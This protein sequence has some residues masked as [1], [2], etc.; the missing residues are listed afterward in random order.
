[1][2]EVIGVRF[3]QAG[4]IYYFDPGD[5]DLTT[6]DYVI[7]ETVRGVE[8]GKVVISN[9]Q[10]DEEDVVLPLKKVIRIADDKD[11]LTVSENNEMTEEAVRTCSD[12][13]KEHQL[14]MNLVDAEYTFDRN[15]IIFYFTADGRV[16]FRHL[17]K[18]LAAVF[19]TRIELRQIG[20][21]DE[22]KMLGGIGPC[23]RMLCCSTF[24]GD[25]EP[26]SIK[27]AKDQN[28]S[29]NPAKISGLCGRLMC[30]LKYENDMYEDAKQE[31]PDIGERLTTSHGSGKVV[32]LN[33]LERLVQVE[34]SEME[35]VVEYTLDELIDEGAISVPA[36]E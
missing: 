15:K 32:G 27:M 33:M 30:C 23:G 13:I 12:K 9:K 29:L 4:K 34:L 21:R 14:D 1:M 28:L 3:K 20:V 16:D 26:V 2:L 5:A 19:K 36:A 17:V 6:D 8:F 22:A 11:K 31:L 10:V 25:F 35:R 24:L 7:V 18:D